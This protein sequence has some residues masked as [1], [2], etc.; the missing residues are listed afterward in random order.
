MLPGDIALLKSAPD[1]PASDLGT[2]TVSLGRK[3]LGWHGDMETLV[4]MEPVKIEAAWRA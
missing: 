4:V 2:I 1:A 3:L